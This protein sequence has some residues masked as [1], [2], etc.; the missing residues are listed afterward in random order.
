MKIIFYLDAV[1]SSDS[2]CHSKMCPAVKLNIRSDQIS[3]TTSHL[4]S[5]DKDIGPYA[6]KLV[7][8]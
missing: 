2:S 3:E 8:D 7:P 4:G 1:D 6:Q 5:P